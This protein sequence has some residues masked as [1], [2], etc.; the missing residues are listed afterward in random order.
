MSQGKQ[1]RE[2]DKSDSYYFYQSEE[3]REQG[4][5]ET[6]EYL[7]IQ[8]WQDLPEA[9]REVVVFALNQ[10]VESDGGTLERVAGRR[11]AQA[12]SL[13]RWQHT[14]RLAIAHLRK[15]AP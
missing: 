10:K 4:N 12:N 14:Y 11:D 3:E 1:P 7:E 5:L 2:A 8:E 9:V 15:V 13:R 6:R